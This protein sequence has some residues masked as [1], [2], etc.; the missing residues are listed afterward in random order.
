MKASP[1]RRPHGCYPDE[2]R[3]LASDGSTVSDEHLDWMLGWDGLVKLLALTEEG[4]FPANVVNRIIMRLFVPGYEQARRYFEKA[5]DI[6]VVDE[7]MPDDYFLQ[8][9]LQSII[10]NIPRL[11]T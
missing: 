8:S 1:L 2:T 7:G 11:E 5:I 9:Q 6:G 10:A 4:E 3:E